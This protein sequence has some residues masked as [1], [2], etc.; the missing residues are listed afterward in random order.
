MKHIVIIAT[1]CLY[2]FSCN[3][4]K[5]NPASFGSCNGSILTDSLS[6]CANFIGTWNWTERYCPCCSG[7]KPTKADKEVTATFNPDA[8]FS[9]S[10][11]LKIIDTG[12]WE[13]LKTSN[14]FAL[15]ISPLATD[16]FYLQGSI[17]ICDNQ[18][19]ADMSFLDGCEHLFIKAD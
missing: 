13:V 15:S 17:T 6:M 3:Q 10:E 11:D 18:L 7:A 9:V 1:F 19:V 2:F 4:E 8:T 5:I 14:G 16:D 12:K